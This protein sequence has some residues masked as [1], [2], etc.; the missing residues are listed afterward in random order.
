MSHFNWKSL[1]FYGIAIS[2]VVVL[3]KVVTAYGETQLKAPLPMGGSYRIDAKNL[4]GC[5]KSDSLLLNIKQSGSY[6]FASLLPANANAQT[7]TAAAQ[8]P[9]LSG[10]LGNQQLDLEGSLPQLKNCHSSAAPSTV[11]IQG[12]VDK[13]ILTGQITLSSNPT[14]TKFTAKQEPPEEKPE[15]KH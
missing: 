11:K 15:N 14:A 9:S 3:F 1:A 2:S 13:D 6:L 12:T 5:L 8:K 10:Q 4:P 7:V